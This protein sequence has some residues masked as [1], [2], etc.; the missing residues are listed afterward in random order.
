MR[1][2]LD[3]CSLQRP[4]DSKTQT[5]IAVEAEAILS[6]IAMI[7]SGQSELVSSQALTFEAEQI[8]LPI[9]KSYVS[10]ILSK[11]ALF[12][13][14]QQ[15]EKEARIYVSEGIKPLDALHL[16]SSVAAK[17]DYFCTCDDRLLKRAKQSNTGSTKVVSPL[18]F[19]LEFE[20]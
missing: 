19:I 18:E 17:A 7:E 16:A 11:A 10:E 2:Y 20:S 15:I 5:R 13:P 8:T 14:T 1:I 12:I 9:R 3:M 4:L 6:I